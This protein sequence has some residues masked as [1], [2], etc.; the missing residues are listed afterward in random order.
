MQDNI[1][2]IINNASSIKNDNLLKN[3]D[4]IIKKIKESLKTNA[5]LLLATNKIDQK[6][7]NGFIMDSK[8]IDNIFLNIEKE[9]SKYGNVITSKKDTEKGLIY[10][11]E[12]LDIGNVIVINDGNPYVIIEMSLRNILAGNKTIFV[13]SGYMYGTNQLIIKIMQTVLEQFNISKY[14]L[15]LCITESYEDVLS[16]YANIDLVV[17]IGNNHL[18]RLILEKS[19]SKTITS[20]YEN[21]D[22][23]IED[24]NNLDFLNTILNTGVNINLYINKNTNLDCPDAILV[25]DIDEAIAQ[26]N[27][28]GNTYSTSIFT[29]SSTNASRFIKEIKSSIVTVNTSPTIER[30][31]DLK[32]SALSLEKTII[33][34]L[35]FTITNSSEKVDIKDEIF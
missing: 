4:L 26:I 34:P 29:K 8:I 14:L 3:I 19:K 22:L 6:N 28:N 32:Q 2:T 24:T 20:G 27:Y 31:I 30:I 18:Q 9:N 5:E 35:N 11:K 21:F 1:T 16:H 10:G 7:N 17:C 15:Q 33:Y 23:Y 13:N 25:D 12:L